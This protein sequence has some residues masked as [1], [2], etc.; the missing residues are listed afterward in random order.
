MVRPLWS[1]QSTNFHNANAAAATA[2][3]LVVVVV[4]AVAEFFRNSSSYM[5]K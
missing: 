4:A 2:S 5:N 3:V 1:A